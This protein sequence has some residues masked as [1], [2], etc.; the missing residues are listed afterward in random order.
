M[1]NI[2]VPVDFSETAKNSAIYAANIAKEISAQ[3][4]ILYNAYSMPLATEM[5]WAVLQTEELQKAS[6]EGLRDYKTELEMVCGPNIMVETVSDFGFLAERIDTVAHEVQA[7]L[8][9]MGITGGG[10]L[11]QVLMGSNTTHVVNHTT[12]PVLIVP[13]DAKW[14]DVEIVGWA[15]DYKDVQQTTPATAISN[16]VDALKAKLVVM[17]NNPDPKAF[18]PEL[19][20]N[21]VM[22][23]E[24]FKR[25]KPDFDM[26]SE[27]NFLD[28]TQAFVERQRIDVLLVIPKRASWFESLFKRSH[29]KLLAFHSHIPLL[30]LRA[31]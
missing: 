17:H 22:V 3:K 7:D 12:V 4:L 30:C 31:L 10:K 18:D 28:A 27:E 2:L 14:K 13:S 6:E 29:T 5:S 26:V 9:I 15:C 11:E 1:N 25:L 8:I 21:N 24:M 16:I 23:A 19:F 20:H